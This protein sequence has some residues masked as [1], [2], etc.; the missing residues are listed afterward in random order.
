[1]MQC[2][3]IITTEFL[4]CPSILDLI[5]TMQTS[6]SL[7][8]FFAVAHLF[9]YKYHLAKQYMQESAACFNLFFEDFYES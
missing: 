4:I 7:A 8:D 3:A 9:S 2:S 1:M 6:C 5:T